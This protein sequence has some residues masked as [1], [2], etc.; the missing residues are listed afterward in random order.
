MPSNVYPAPHPAPPYVETY[1]GPVLASPRIVPVFFSNDD[2]TMV[3]E[4][5]DFV[6]KVGATKYWAANTTEYGVGPATGAPP[7]DLTEA[8][9]A[10]IDDTQVQSWLAGKLNGDDPAWPATDENTVYVLH[11][12]AGTTITADD[13]MGG[14]AKSCQSFGGYHSN[15][16]LDDAHG[17][18]NVAYAV[19]PRCGNFDMFTGID[20][21]TGA[22]SHELLEAVTDPYPQVNPAYGSCDEAHLYWLFALGGG[23]TGDMCA[24]LPGAFNQFDELPYVVQRSWS[25]QSANAG[26]DPCVP[27][28]PG[29]VYFNAAPVLSDDIT[30]NYQGQPL[31]MKGVKIPVGETKTIEVDLF[32]EADTGGPWNV[33]VVDYGSFTGQPSTLDLSLDR[34]S[35]QNGEKLHLTITATDASPYKFAPFFL[36]SEQNGQQ[37]FWI[38]MVGN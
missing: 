31:H 23:E 14:L 11:Y 22:E 24:Q 38:G 20:A 9:P 33:Q 25:N 19:V 3:T 37:N 4:L 35:G 16:T 6:S 21:V 34:D 36:I 12:P 29:S 28:L 15:I 1:G 13:G 27:A 18:Q 17:A 30:V 5:K 8:A 10:K 26:H 2:P 7:V 32:S